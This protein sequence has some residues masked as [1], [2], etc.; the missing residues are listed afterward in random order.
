MLPDGSE[1]SMNENSTFTYPKRFK[2]KNRKVK[3]TGEAFFKVTPDKT[4]PFIVDLNE[5]Y[6]KVL[7]TQFNINNKQGASEISVLL[8]EGRVL[9]G[10]GKNNPDSLVLRKGNTGIYNKANQ[11]LH[12][13][14]YSNLNE[15]AWKTKILVF[16]N[17]ILDNVIE[18]IEE[19]YFIELKVD[20]KLKSR[21]ISAIYYNQPIEM[22]LQILASTLN[23]DINEIEKNNYEMVSKIE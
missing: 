2:G 1:I 8:T 17:E 3:L 20:E 10:L 12:L 14:D 19:V 18:K 4:K 11:T 6:V 7:G 13:E 16:D 15:T 23:I 21:K 9:F 5:T 22:I